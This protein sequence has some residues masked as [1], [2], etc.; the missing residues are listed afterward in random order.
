M[1]LKPIYGKAPLTEMKALML[2]PGQVRMADDRLRKAYALCCAWG[3]ERPALWEPA[4][5]LAAV[6]T[7]DA[8][9]EPV[10][11]WIA[12]ALD[13]QED[14]GALP[15]ALIE[16]LHVMR[17]AWAMYEAAP[18]RALLERM[19]RWCGWLSAHWDE[20]EACA[21]LRVRP[22]DLMGLLCDL[23]RVTGKKGLT[24]LCKR[25]RYVGMDWSGILHTFAVQRPMK[26]II[27]AAELAEG[28]AAEA[29]EEAGFYTRQYLTCHGETLAD[30]ARASLMNAA[31][32]GN[33]HEA[34]AAME[35]WEKISRWHGAVCGGITADETLGGASP[36][37]AVDAACLGAWAEAFAAQLEADDAIWARDA[38]EV[39]LANGLS[40][41]WQE[42]ELIPFQRVNGLWANCGTEDCY[43]VHEGDEQAV[44]VLVRVARGWSAAAYTAVSSCPAGVKVNLYMPG[45]Y[46][47]KLA[48]V[49]V[50]LEVFGAKGDYTI[51]V[52]AKQPVKAALSLAVPF[53]AE[54]ARIRVN[55]ERADEGPMGRQ[56]TLERTWQAGDTVHIS[57]ARAL[58]MKEGY[59]QSVAVFYGAE[60]MAY[61]A[62]EQQWAVALCGAPF[63]RD[64]QVVAPL[65]RIPGW[66]AEHGVPGDLP[67]RPMM[68]GKLFEAVLTPYAETPCRVALLPR[69]ARA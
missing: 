54:D 65:A 16:A 25:L 40:A 51:T 44:R 12:E 27:S 3:E 1:P 26:R 68:T 67:V 7:E 29:G 59:H 8:Q 5:R 64:G 55:D 53:W 20:A 66:K 35:G 15:V 11:R 18:E 24:A 56:L 19:M 4:F 69:S 30:G 10:A 46:T 14:S 48:G 47:V 58:R 23:Y 33:K 36:S 49:T 6:L 21:E 28:M 17:A 9:N 37:C 13:K 38:L 34:T 50:R 32:S 39:L 31:Y 63:L 61:P 57:F 43:R 2:R 52:H 62:K 60:M 42:G 45:S 41:V 22:A